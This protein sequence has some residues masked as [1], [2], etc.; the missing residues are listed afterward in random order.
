LSPQ[1]KNLIVGEQRLVY[2]RPDP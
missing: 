1:T 2:T